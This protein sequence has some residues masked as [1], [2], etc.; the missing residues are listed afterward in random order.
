MSTV[1]ASLTGALITGVFALS[2]ALPA[3]AQD[4]MDIGVIKRSDIAVVQKL[5]YPKTGRTEMGVHLGLMPFDAYLTT[6]NLQL[7]YDSHMSESLSW[8]VMLGGG[9]GFDTSTLQE[10][11]SP[12]YG[13]S[14]DAYRYLGSI[15]GGVAW[16][17]IYAKMNLDGA[18]VIH[19]DVY[20]SARAGATFSQSILPE[21]GSALAPTLS[22]GV[23][24]RFFLNKNGNI[25][26]ELHDDLLLEKRELT[27]SMF[28]KHNINISVGYTVL[29]GQ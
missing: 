10:L 28:L 8:G 26:V 17:P 14:P 13:V 5:L 11:S 3:A 12:A 22:L 21:G 6:P 19:Y 15:L 18:K 27:D 16:S 24:S 4:A 25:R 7:S 23:G 2:F 20:T 29:S 9:Y 1:R